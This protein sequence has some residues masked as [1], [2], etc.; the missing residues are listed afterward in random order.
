MATTASRHGSDAGRELAPAIASAASRV[1]AGQLGERGG[2]RFEAREPG[3]VASRD[4]QQPSPVRL[5][6]GLV[7]GRRRRGRRPAP[8]RPARH[9]RRR[10]ARG[11]PRPWPEGRRTWRPEHLPVVGVPRQV[12]GQGDA[13]PEHRDQ[14]VEQLEPSGSA[15]AATSAV[16][17][18]GAG[19][20]DD[21]RRE[22]ASAASGSADRAQR[23]EQPVVRHERARPGSGVVELALPP[24]GHRRTRSRASRP[25]AVDVRPAAPPPDRR[26]SRSD[27][28]R[29]AV[30]R[31]GR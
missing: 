19:G 9:R 30:Q 4:H 23:G 21:A 10:A 12:I 25:V 2:G 26:G 24:R 5:T 14:A 27:P 18:A 28:L 13:G 17:V 16:R 8:G 6:Q 31:T 15:R 3:E 1:A 22:P 29:P 11:A 20:I 7:A